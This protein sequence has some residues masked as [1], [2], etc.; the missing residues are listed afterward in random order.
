MDVKLRPP[1]LQ[2]WLARLVDSNFSFPISDAPITESPIKRGNAVDVAMEARLAKEIKMLEFNPPPGVSAWPVE[3]SL[4]HLHADVQGPTDSPYEGGV[5]R[6]DVQIPSRYPN[7]PPQIR[8]HTPIY[9]P[10][11]DSGGRICLDALKMPPTV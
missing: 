4:I 7:E 2:I 9:H 5:F 6:L 1:E 10:N 3:D 8:F 11:I